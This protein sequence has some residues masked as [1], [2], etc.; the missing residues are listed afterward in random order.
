MLAKLMASQ[1]CRTHGAMIKSLA[2]IHRCLW[3]QNSVSVCCWKI[4]I[5][6]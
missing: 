1:S 4:N 3:V 2:L 6:N 5:H